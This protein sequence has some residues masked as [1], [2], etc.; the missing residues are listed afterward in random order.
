MIV[1][2]TE[3]EPK[4]AVITPVCFCVRPLVLAWKLTTDCPTGTGTEA[5]GFRCVLL[6]ETLRATPVDVAAALRVT[7]QLN[8]DP[9]LTDLGVQPMATGLK[10]TSATADCTDVLGRVAV[11]VA[12]SS[13]LM[14]EAVA[15]NAAPV[16]P[17]GTRTRVGTVNCAVLEESGTFRPPAGA[18]AG[19]VRAQVDWPLPVSTC[20]LHEIEASEG[21]RA[22]RSVTACA[23]PPDVETEA[24]VLV[25]T[26]AAL[27]VNVAL[28]MPVPIVTEVG[29][30]RLV[31]DES[32]ETEVLAAAGLASVSVHVPVP[33]VWMVVGVQTRVAFNGW[34]TV[35]TVV[36]ATVVVVAVMLTLMLPPSDAALAVKFAVL[37]PTGMV[38]VAGTVT[39]EL[40]LANFTVTA[41]PEATLLRVTEHVLEV[42]CATLA[43]MQLTDATLAEVRTVKGNVVTAPFIDAVNMA[44]KSVTGLPAVAEKAT[45]LDPA[46]T[47]T[48]AGTDT[49]GLSLFSMTV[50]PPAEAFPVRVRVQLAEVVVAMAPG[51]QPRL[52]S[53]ALPA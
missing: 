12:R 24:G 10:L 36:R 5:G 25:V 8:G 4:L 15:L 44:V 49:A 9:A 40:L 20:G 6:V 32:S 52:A 22:A 27:M 19:S 30:V 23:I 2:C 31:E 43:G 7:W 47:R 14:T 29:M 16:L 11:M 53:A 46:V 21:S 45:L 42:P 33:G 38:T 1:S 48:L 41:A 17:W 26:A 35:R 3:W 28:V 37:M 34:N 18:G 39:L 13:L 50:K 51:V